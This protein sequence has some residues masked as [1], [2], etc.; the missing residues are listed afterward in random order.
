MVT[1]QE[2]IILQHSSLHD[3]HIAGN[4]AKGPIS[5]QVFQE[6]KARQIFRKT[7]ISYP[8][9]RTR[10][11]VCKSGGK[12]C[13]FFGKFDMICFLETSVLIFALLPCYRQNVHEYLW[14]LSY[15][16][17]LFDC[18]VYF[19]FYLHF[20]MFTHNEVYY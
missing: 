7:D 5:K 6:N 13:T 18:T 2:M 15:T 8:L 10:T 4:K 1:M 12:K 14:Q 3:F 20:L 9:K 19:I 11:Y 16:S 17:R